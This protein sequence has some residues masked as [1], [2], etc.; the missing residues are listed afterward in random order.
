[1]QHSIQIESA[2]GEYMDSVVI[3]EWTVPVGAAVKA[4]DTIVT[5]ETAKAATE[6]PAPAD[7]YL[8][9]IR[10]EVGQEAA[11]GEVLGIVADTSELPAQADASAQPVP[12]AP[13]PA[14]PAPSAA[15]A[16]T[17][18]GAL[19]AQLRANRR[20][21]SPLARRSARALGVDLD[22][23]IGT[24]PRGRIKRADVEAAK[25][26]KAVSSPI[27]PAPAFE[28]QPALSP[29]G[30]VAPPP[31][32]P[33]V[34]GAR[35][36]IVLIHGFGADRASWRTIAGLLASDHALV[37]PDLPG[38][39]VV[40]SANVTTIEDLAFAVSDQLRAKGVETAHVIGHSLGGAVAIALADLGLVAPRSLGLIAPGGMG[41]EINTGF[42]RGLATARRVEDLQPWLELMVAD[43]NVLPAGLASAVLR[44]RGNQGAELIALADAL[45]GEGTQTMRLATRLGRLE[46]PSKVIWGRRDRV[47]PVAQTADLPGHI[48]LHLLAGVGHVPQMEA[49]GMVARLINELVRSGE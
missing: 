30:S 7:G 48:G 39:G 23:V 27:M 31:A 20:S 16:A 12:L 26:A 25:S 43:P 34:G 35:A 21:A 3:L 9:E 32:P 2:G 13:P 19:L 36:P 38:H 1:M 5:V 47:I 49:P 11:V 45:F 14:P 40:S 17:G 41:P 37:M 22:Q 42:I 29:T 10:F 15:E 33:V 4:G 18:D 6:V 8:V 24:G 46:M 28:K 44:Q